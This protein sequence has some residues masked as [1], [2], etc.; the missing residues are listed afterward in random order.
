MSI[1]TGYFLHECNRCDLK[2]I[3]KT[4]KPGTCANQKCRS[5]YW[6]KVRKVFAKS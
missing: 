6:N 5:P 1:P 3:S 4:E 2:W